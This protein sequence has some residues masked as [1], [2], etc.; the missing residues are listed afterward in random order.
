MLR[1]IQAFLDA[2]LDWSRARAAARA[3]AIPGGAHWYHGLVPVMV[4]LAAL[5]GLTGFAM[6]SVYAPTTRD[7]WSSVSTGP[8]TNSVSRC[9]SMWLN[10][11]ST[12]S[13]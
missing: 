3:A 7:A 8:R 13:P 11:V 9:G 6:A 4:A 10:A 1:A 2:R 5:E 12:A